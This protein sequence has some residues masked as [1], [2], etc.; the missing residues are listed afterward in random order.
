MLKAHLLE[1][2]PGLVM[3]MA[4][5][6]GLEHEAAARDGVG[7]GGV[8]STLARRRACSKVTL[9]SVMEPHARRRTHKD[10]GAA[11]LGKKGA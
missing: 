6:S 3:L 1:A 11:R 7:L 5:V 4:S 8:V 10:G 2:G 9:S